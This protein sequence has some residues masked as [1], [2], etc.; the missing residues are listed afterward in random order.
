MTISFEFS[1]AQLGE[2]DHLCTIVIEYFA[3]GWFIGADYTTPCCCFT[4]A[5]F[6]NEAECFTLVD[7]EIQPVNRLHLPDDPVPAA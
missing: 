5:T 1:V 4:A 2:V 7:R 3:I 6:T